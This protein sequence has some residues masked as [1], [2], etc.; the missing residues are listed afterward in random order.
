MNK[1]FKKFIP[2]KFKDNSRVWV[3]QSSKAF[4]TKEALEIMER[5]QEFSKQWHS[6]GDSVDNFIHLFF[7]RFIVLMA[8]ESNIMVSGCSTDSSIKFLKNLEKDYHVQ[9]FN[10]QILAFIVDQKIITVPLEKVNQAIESEMING[11][12]LYFNNTILTKKDLLNKWII[13]VKESWLAG[14]IPQFTPIKK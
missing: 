1:E 9:L 2:E 8:D 13:P 3:Y 11:D 12:T 7:D 6:H 10:R 4:T 5:L 14:R